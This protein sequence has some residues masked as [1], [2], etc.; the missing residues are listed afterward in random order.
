M[1]S[2]PG[3]SVSAAYVWCSRM[4]DER[5]QL[6]EGQRRRAMTKA[7]QSSKEPSSLNAHRFEWSGREILHSSCC[8]LCCAPLCSA[9][10]RCAL[11]LRL[12]RV[13]F[14]SFPPHT[15]TSSRPHHALPSFARVH[16]A[17]WLFHGGLTDFLLVSLVPVLPSSI[18]VALLTR[19]S[20]NHSLTDSTAAGVAVLR[21][22]SVCSS[23]FIPRPSLRHAFAQAHSATVAAAA[24]ARRR[25]RH[26]AP[27]T[28]SWCAHTE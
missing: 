22:D 16:T 21:A 2:R 12:L 20:L 13:L 23:P 11:L 15:L 14:G 18:I 27:P 7:M 24:A 28:S 6:K 3:G 19:H 9:V 5:T 25:C 4:N 26:C 17:H 1:T 8:C 10:L